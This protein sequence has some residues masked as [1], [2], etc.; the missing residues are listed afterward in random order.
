MSFPTRRFGP[1][2]LALTLIVGLAPPA[3]AADSADVSA[4]AIRSA[5]HRALA[6]TNQR[7]AAHGLVALRWDER[8]AELARDRAVYMADTGRFSH[9][10]AGGTSVF[11]MI[12]DANIRWY[13]AGEILA[14]NTA[15]ALDYSADFAV[16]GWMGSPGH[17]AIVLSDG[18]NYVGFGLAISATT[19]VRY[20]AGVYLKGP[21]RTAPTA[22]VRSFGKTIL[23]ARYARVT[24]RWAGRDRRLQVLT[25]GL[26]YFQVKWRRDGGS[27]FQYGTTSATSIQRRWERGHHYELR[28]RSRD[29]AGNWGEWVTGY[30]RP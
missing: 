19:G 23:S 11:D 14:W 1:F 13:G 18:Y 2:L 29:R 24:L 15:A 28:V 25:S 10:Q 30:Y 6:L 22:T 17:R 8:L 26:R 16:K 27:W 5:E 12:E 21:D 3:V 4:A 9:T 20:W 7:R